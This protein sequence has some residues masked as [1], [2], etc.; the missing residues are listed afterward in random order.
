MKLNWNRWVYDMVNQMMRHVGT[1]GLTWGGLT[2]KHGRD[3]NGQIWGDLGICLLCG[4]ILPTI[5]N[6]L[7]TTGLPEDEDRQPPKPNQP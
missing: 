5:F 7:Q 1:A 2:I 3:L 4:A 6:F